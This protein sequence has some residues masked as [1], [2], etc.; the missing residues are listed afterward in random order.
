MTATLASPLLLPTTRR[1]HAQTTQTPLTAIT[2]A[3]GVC[4]DQLDSR[5]AKGSG[6]PPALSYNRRGA[7]GLVDLQRLTTS[8]LT[9]FPFSINKRLLLPLLQTW[10][11]VNHVRRQDVTLRLTP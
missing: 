9:H 6:R 11:P 5:A 4:A 7:S 1:N 10:E 3:V 2:R 8:T